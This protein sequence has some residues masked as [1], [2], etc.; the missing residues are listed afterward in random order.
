MI[1]AGNLVAFALAAWGLILI[2]GPSMLFVIG[3]SLSLGR[4]GGLLSVVGNA[5]GALV[6]A[7]A[8]A[9]G[10]GVIIEQS[11]IV[12]TAVKIVGALYLVYLGIQTIRHRNEA[13]VADGAAIA[14]RSRL[15]ILGE[16]FL[17]GIS[18]PKIIVFF[19]AV[20][21]QFVDRSAGSIP[22]QLGVF[23]AIFVVIALLSDS[24]WAII[25]GSARQWFGKSPKRIG[26]LRGIGGVM[27]IGLGVAVLFVGH[28]GKD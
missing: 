15:R 4:I 7:S 3:R 25:A 1:P 27:M 11:L 20:L 22:L 26:R 17:V 28:G 5:A 24:V 10:L 21:P 13:G 8:V 18:N 12:F 6:I 19:I 2:P 23:G 16:G 9:L 14:P